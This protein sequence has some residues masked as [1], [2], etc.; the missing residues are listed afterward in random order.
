M[1]PEDF[2]ILPFSYSAALNG[3][4]KNKT[5]EGEKENIA[6]NNSLHNNTADSSVIEKLSSTLNE[7]AVCDEGHKVKSEKLNKEIDMAKKINVS[8]NS[9]SKAISSN[10]FKKLPRCAANFSSLK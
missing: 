1:P 5:Q 2:S 8:K 7:I 9:A 4:S 3:K 6:N 10:N